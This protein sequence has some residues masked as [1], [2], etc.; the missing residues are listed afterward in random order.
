[1]SPLLH[2]ISHNAHRLTGLVAQTLDLKALFQVSS[3]I[4]YEMS[5]NLFPRNDQR[6]SRRIKTVSYTHLTLPTTPYV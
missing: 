3:H 2:L 1:M 5:R 4:F 6:D